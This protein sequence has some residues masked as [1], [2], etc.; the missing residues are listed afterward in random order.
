MRKAKEESLTEVKRTSEVKHEKPMIR[1]SPALPK[2]IDE[3]R[4]E[5]L[6][7]S[8]VKAEKELEIKSPEFPTLPPASTDSTPAIIGMFKTL[9]TT[10]RRIT[11][12]ALNVIAMRN[13]GHAWD[14]G[15]W[16]KFCES[17]IFYSDRICKFFG[18]KGKL[19]IQK[20]GRYTYLKYRGAKI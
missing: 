20:S 3:D 10:K 19:F 7:F 18:A 11:P 6:G 16:L 4:K 2:T 8:T 9:M 12:Q 1:S 14:R 13:D 15:S 17:A 5:S